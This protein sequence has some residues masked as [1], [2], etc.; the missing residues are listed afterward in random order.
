[1]EEFRDDLIIMIKN[2]PLPVIV[3]LKC[4]GQKPVMEVVKGD[5]L[6]FERLL[7]NQTSSQSIVLKNVSAIPLMWNLSGLDEIAEEF[8]F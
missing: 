6:K 2:N 4:L 7:L 8:S 1:M 5:G 3:P